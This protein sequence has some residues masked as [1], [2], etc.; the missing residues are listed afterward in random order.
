MRYNKSMP[1]SYLRFNSLALALVM[2]GSI[3]AMGGQFYNDWAASRFSDIPTLTGTTNDPDGDGEIN[4][5]E[6]AF[7][8]DPR[9]AGGSNGAIN[10][11]YGS[12]GGT[13]GIF[14]V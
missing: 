6:F 9:T 3:P 8:T 10:P 13:N 5:V 7:G 1:L 2:S 12:P 11:K 14:S 4:L